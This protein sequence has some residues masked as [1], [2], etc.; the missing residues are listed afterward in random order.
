MSFPSS[1]P[2]RLTLV[3]SSLGCGGA[4]RLVQ[5]MTNYWAERGREVTI[6]TLHGDPSFYSLHPKA[7]HVALGVAANSR[8]IL[9]ALFNNLR[10]IVVLRRAIRKSAPD[11]VIS[12]LD[13]TNVLT[14]LATAGLRLPVIVSEQSDLLRYDIGLVWDWLRRITYRRAKAVVFPTSGIP[15]NFQ[16]LAKKR[17][18]VI[19]NPVVVP[20]GMRR[21]TGPRDADGKRRALV[22]MG[23]LSRVKGFDLLLRAFSIAASKH[24]EWS[25][26]ILGEGP[27][28]RE[29]EDQARSLELLDRVRLPGRVANPFPC[30]RQ[31]DLFVLSSLSEGFGYA[32]CEAMACGLPVV[33]FDCSPGTREIIRDGVDGIL[34]PPEDVNALAGVLEHLMGDA[35]E[36][37]RLAQ[38]APEVVARFGLE[39]V[40]GLWEAVLGELAEGKTPPR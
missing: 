26:T 15:A 33:S 6:L 31:A 1:K 8:N 5:I 18:R 21:D 4:E 38:R 11:V 29:L 7:R 22:A 16:P 40:M 3:I 14:L 25:L 23:R 32:L 34:V 35:T 39:K 20:E 36:R 17:G 9:Q 24:P 13:K 2:M 12:V 30:L 37:A 19:P 10:R 27:Q 28:R